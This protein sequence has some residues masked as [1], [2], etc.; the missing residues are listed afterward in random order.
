M[1]RDAVLAVLR[2]AGDGWV[3]GEELSRSL[4][5]SRTAVWKLMESLRAAGYQLEAVP[6]QGYRLI[7]SPDAVTPH[8]VVP[9]LTT[10]AFGR[11]IEYRESVGST[12][13][14]AKQMARAGA[15]EGLLVIADE[16][17][18][19]KGRLGRAWTTP[20]G[21]AIAMSLV[22]RP[23]LSPVQAPRVTLVAAVAVAEAVREVTGLPV[24]IKWPND[25][26]LQGRKF[27]GILTEME[28][29]IDRIA[30][31]VCG[32]GLN[33]NLPRESLP[34]EFRSSA[35]SLMAEL[36]A[37]V[38][39]A[40]LV[41]AVLARLETVYGELIA[42][43]F[44]AVLDRWRALSITL[45]QP[46][47]VLSVTGEATVEGVAEDVDEEGALLVRESASGVLRRVFAGEV[48]LRPGAVG[49]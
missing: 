18:A 26:Q 31:I 10:L 42:G 36:G 1:S 44:D 2:A 11:R 24:G 17:T 29:E 37:P 45:G 9:G 30:F 6:R 5:V 43:R 13:D 14:L 38:S 35:T 3:S 40:A 49:A 48:T 7:A 32:M 34:E 16:Q 47:R 41:Q 21:S 22:L 28:A 46:V 20:R 19:G 15:P 8:E 12:N 33:V 25:L 4:G 27:C 23:E 39:R